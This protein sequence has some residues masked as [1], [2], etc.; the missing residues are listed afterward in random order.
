MPTEPIISL[1]QLQMRTTLQRRT[2]VAGIVTA[3]DVGKS[4]FMQDADDGIQVFPSEKTNVRPGDRVE[5]VGYPTPGDYGNVVRDAV[6]RVTGNG[7]LP[8]PKHVAEETPLDPQLNDMW[9]E[10]DAQVANEPETDPEP[11]LPLQIGTAIFKARI[12][13]PVV[14]KRLPARGSTVHI[15]GVYQRSL[16]DDMRASRAFR[17]EVPSDN[18]VQITSRPSVWTFQHAMLVVGTLVIVACVGLLWILLLR[19][20]VAE[21][22]AILQQSEVKFRSLVEQSL[23]GVY[24]IQDGH[25]TYV[26]PRLAEIYGYSVEELT[27]PSFNLN[28]T[29]L[30]EDRPIVEEQLDGRTLG[31]GSKAH[32]TYRARRKDGQTVHM[33]VMGSQSRSTMEKPAI[34]GTAMDITERKLAE[35]RLAEASNLLD[36]LLGNIP[37]F[38]YFKDRLSRFVRA[39]KAFEKLFGLSDVKSLKGKTDFD[40]FVGDH[41]RLAFEDEQEIMRTGKPIIGKL[42]SEM[43]S[44]GRMTHAL[45]TKMPWRDAAGNIIGTFGISKDVTAF[46]ETEAKLALERDLLHTLMENFPDVI[47]FKDLKSKFVRVSRSKMASSMKIVLGRHQAEHPGEGPEQLPEHLKSVEKLGEWLV[48]KSDFDT[49]AQGRAQAAYD[50]EQQIIKT[51]ELD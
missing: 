24:V 15:A 48:G 13:T 27:A 33:E 17:L 26:N 34:M 28:D 51:G 49:F 5:V 25:F 50:D 30:E 45:T 9:V 3:Y 2:K 16:Q 10:A 44:D 31:K 32:Y 41:A 29:V 36:T 1:S 39:S 11:V 46:K 47:Y 23:V 21:Q 8:A 43:H 18:N 37:D 22:T 4:F 20:K 19:R 40:F 6:F 35:T 7:P 14:A 42:E 12:L 38:I